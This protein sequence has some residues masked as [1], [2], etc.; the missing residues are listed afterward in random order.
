MLPIVFAFYEANLVVA[1]R[2]VVVRCGRMLELHFRGVFDDADY[3]D[4]NCDK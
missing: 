1:K 2:I 3:D 4:W